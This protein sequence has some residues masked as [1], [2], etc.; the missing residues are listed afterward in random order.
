MNG[1][2]VVTALE[3][4]FKSRD[5]VIKMAEDND[6]KQVPQVS[7]DASGIFLAGNNTPVTPPAP[8]NPK[9]EPKPDPKPE[10][11]SDPVKPDPIQPP[12][13]PAEPP[14]VN[15]VNDGDLLIKTT[16]I[17][18]RSYGLTSLPPAEM[19]KQKKLRQGDRRV[20]VLIDDQEV[21]FKLIPVGT[22]F[23]RI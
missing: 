12:V 3:A 22:S 6:H 17:R 16:I 19:M 11:A 7:G 23:T 20:K 14:V 1:D 5:A 9:P 15:V 2:K 13:T 18:D 10:P 21:N 4:F 8:V